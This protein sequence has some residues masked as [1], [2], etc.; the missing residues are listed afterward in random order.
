MTIPIIK[1]NGAP[2]NRNDILK[3]N[4]GDKLTLGI[5]DIYLEETDEEATQIV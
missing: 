3:L 5:T 1:L 4:F 2:I